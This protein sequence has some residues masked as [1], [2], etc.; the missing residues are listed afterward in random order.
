MAILCV[1]VFPR[2]YSKD[3]F[4]KAVFRTLFIGGVPIPICNLLMTGGML[5]KCLIVSLFEI[6]ILIALRNHNI[7]STVSSN[8]QE[9]NMDLDSKYSRYRGIFKLNY[10]ARGIFVSST[11]RMF[12]LSAARFIGS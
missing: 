10:W 3:F 2:T 4:Q 5:A 1:F 12:K 11:W 7:K 6:I 9:T 8:I